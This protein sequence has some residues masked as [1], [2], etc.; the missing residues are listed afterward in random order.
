MNNKYQILEVIGEGAYGIV[1]KCKNKK[2]NEI[3]AIKKFLEEY[4][5]LPK[6]EINREIYALQISKHENIVKFIEAFLNKGYLYLVFEYAEK[7][8]LQIIEENPKGLNP[9]QIRSFI[10]QICSAVSYLHKKN[11]IHRDIKPE[12]ILI[13][14]NTQIELC[15]FGFARKMKINKE[16]NNYEKMTEYMATRW[17]RAPELIL[18][19]GIYGPEIDFWSIG[20][21]MGELS[22]GKPMFPGDNQINQLEYIIKL[23]GNLPEEQVNYFN[24]NPVFNVNKLL[25][26]KNPETLEKRYEK[27][28]SSEAIDFMKGLLELDPK[29]RLNSDTV[30]EHKYFECYKSQKQSDRN[31]N[32]LLFSLSID[33]KKKFKIPNI[34]LFDKEKDSNVINIFRYKDESFISETNEST[35]SKKKLKNN[36]DNNDLINYI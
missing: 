13:K 30:F 10:Y 7:N 11:I 14:N 34:K 33:N 1:Y 28:M 12:N 15:D 23:I 20:C 31:D 22:D 19:Q 16:T 25:T 35:L 3:V 4:D 9:E 26:V 24:N 32:N 18:S 29:K 21:I 6:K 5:K 2:T 17:Y 27:I 8:L 36:D